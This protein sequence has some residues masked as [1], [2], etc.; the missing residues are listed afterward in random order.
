MATEKDLQRAGALA[1]ELGALLPT[2]STAMAAQKRDVEQKLA[3][4]ATRES[5]LA[6]REEAL[7]AREAALDTR[8]EKVAAR[9][10]T[11]DQAARSAADREQE[12][13]RK[14]ETWAATSSS[15][16][17]KRSADG[18]LDGLQMQILA[19]ATATA[20]LKHGVMQAK[21]RM[22]ATAE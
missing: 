1:A 17:P 21:E 14:Q 8:E 11:S 5:A 22:K 20:L 6:A 3:Q 2:V 18:K 15:A 7:R 4:L 9:E 12:L 16:V 13:L 10:R 19:R